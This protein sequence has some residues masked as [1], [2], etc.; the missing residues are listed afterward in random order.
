MMPN[1][2]ERAPPRTTR[3]ATRVPLR[4]G[5][6]NNMPDAALVATERQFG[7]LI[8]A[9]GVPADVL[10]FSLP[11]LPRGEAGLRHLREHYRD[12]DELE[13]SSLDA[14]IVTGAPPRFSIFSDE[15]YWPHLARLV[16]WAESHTISTIWSC[17][18]A[19][20]AVFH[21]DG[22]ARRLQPQKVFGVF[23]CAKVSEDPVL[24]GVPARWSVPHSRYNG[25]D[26][27]ALAAYGYRVL[28][29]G[30]QSGA[31]TFIKQYKSLFLF[32]QGHPEYD[33]AALFLEYRRDIEHFL[34][35]KLDRYPNVPLGYVEDDAAEKLQ[36]LQ[37]RLSRN[38]DR[39]DLSA[40]LAEVRTRLKPATWH[41]VAE[42]IYANWLAHVAEHR[43][44]E[45][46]ATESAR[47]PAVASRENEGSA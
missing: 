41:G 18:A 40:T 28:S 19:H 2:I 37:I 30:E 22:V 23:E 20:A 5:L 43:D 33:P 31:D 38:A 45:A 39:A 46:A 10:L 13:A 3:H 32:M 36:E 16:D 29:Q 34:A 7:E 8:A 21:L 12:F 35:G 11:D 17:L 47:V 15:P 6:V 14:L 25:L 26:E 9:S 4:I 27:A 1:P 42:R 24:D 44:R